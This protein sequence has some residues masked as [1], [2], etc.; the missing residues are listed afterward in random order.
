MFENT[1]L[2]LEEGIIKQILRKDIMR[3][4]ITYQVIHCLCF[5][6]ATN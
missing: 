3:E 1:G 2:V 6:A 5:L 4:S